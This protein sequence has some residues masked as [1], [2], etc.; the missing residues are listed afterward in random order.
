MYLENLGKYLD[1]KYYKSKSYQDL[2]S[3]INDFYKKF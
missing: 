2:E 1:I 3:N